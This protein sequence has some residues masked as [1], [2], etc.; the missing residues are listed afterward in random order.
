M[1]LSII[2][3]VYNVEKYIHAC[4]ESIFKQ[5]LDETDFE[6]IIVNDG[7]K[8]RSMEV[9]EDIIA[10]AT[11]ET[12]ADLQLVSVFQELGSGLGLDHDVML[13]NKCGQPDLFDLCGVLFLLGFFFLFLLIVLE[14]AVIKDLADRRFGLRC[15]AYQVQVLLL[16]KAECFIS[17]HDSKLLSIGRNDSH[18]FGTNFFVD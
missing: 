16:S 8:D 10:S 5:G 13:F 14:L 7:T 11:P 6:V 17:G 12:K 18:F 9:I 15:D 4:L 1:K 2:V 3:P